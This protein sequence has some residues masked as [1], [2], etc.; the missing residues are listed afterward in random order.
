MRREHVG[1]QKMLVLETEFFRNF[2][3]QEQGSKVGVLGMII[4][5]DVGSSLAL[6][7]SWGMGLLGAGRWVGEDRRDEQQGRGSHCC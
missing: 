1:K 6:Y 7:S 4:L 5:R 2:W 3:A